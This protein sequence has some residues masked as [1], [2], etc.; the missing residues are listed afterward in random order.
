MDGEKIKKIA[1]QLAVM[2]VFESLIAYRAAKKRGKNPKLY[3]VLTAV[4]GVFVLLPL[5]R[6]PK[7]GK[8]KK[9]DI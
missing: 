4:F 8:E 3:M 5:L 1:K 9:V 6:K 7:L 2:H